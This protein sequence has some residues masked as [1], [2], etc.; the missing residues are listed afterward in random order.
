MVETKTC[1][2]ICMSR[3]L[4]ILSLSDVSLSLFSRL[5][6]VVND[7]FRRAV[8]FSGWQGGPE[9]AV[10]MAASSAPA[11]SNES[12]QWISR[13]KSCLEKCKADGYWPEAAQAAAAAYL[14]PEHAEVSLYRFR[15]A[16]LRNFSPICVSIIDTH[17]YC[18][19]HC[20]GTF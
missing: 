11:E 4:R 5:L 7:F 12:L 6:G 17:I 16:S 1:T 13:L 2:Y 9:P 8:M 19:S 15:P 18:C 3:C 20:G 10:A 14:T